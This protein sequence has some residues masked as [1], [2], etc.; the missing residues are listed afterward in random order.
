MVTAIQGLALLVPKDGHAAASAG[1]AT[2]LLQN[3]PESRR[4][5]PAAKRW[6][7]PQRR[8]VVPTVPEGQKVQIPEAGGRGGPAPPATQ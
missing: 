2:V 3:F 1:T 4:L 6:P 5:Y 8:P 7:R